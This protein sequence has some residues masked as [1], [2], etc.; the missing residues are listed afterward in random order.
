MI[1]VATG[2]YITA[3]NEPP[4]QEGPQANVMTIFL[5]DIESRH[6]PR[7]RNAGRGL[8]PAISSLEPALKLFKLIDPALI[9]E[10]SLV[11]PALRVAD[12]EAI[13]SVG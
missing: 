11:R 6:R 13:S 2:L 8:I 4:P 7:P 5:S 10:K 12:A 3:G 1:T 9:Q